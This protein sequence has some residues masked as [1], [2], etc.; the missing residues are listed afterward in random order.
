VLATE[1]IRMMMIGYD[2]DPD[3]WAI[4]ELCS[5]GFYRGTQKPFYCS[6]CRAL[7]AISHDDVM[8]LAAIMTKTLTAKGLMVILKIKTEYFV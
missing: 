1:G 2:P 8:D 6:K 3:H 7:P 5:S 4:C